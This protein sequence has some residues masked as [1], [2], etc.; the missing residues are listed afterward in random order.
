MKVVVLAGGKGTRLGLNEIPKVLVPV[1]GVPLLERT[2]ADAVGYGFT[3][4]LFLT[5]FRGDVIERHF[6]DGH[7]IRR[8]D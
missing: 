6:G 2:V 4:F 1:G 3:D 5:G 7:R 8:D